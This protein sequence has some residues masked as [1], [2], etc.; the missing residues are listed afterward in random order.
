MMTVST[1]IVGVL[2]LAMLLGSGSCILACGCER[3]PPGMVRGA[4]RT[5]AAQGVPGAAVELR[6]QD[7]E[8][9]R[10]T[11]VT[12]ADGAFAIY[13]VPGQG[14]YALTVQPPQGW[15]LAPGQA[16][17]VSLFVGEQDT[18]VASFILRAP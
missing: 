6:A 7:G 14:S 18:T 16:A 11:I 15:S 4:V 13:P 17:S 12:G 8:D 10:H 3:P 1:K 9:W 5:E 2:A